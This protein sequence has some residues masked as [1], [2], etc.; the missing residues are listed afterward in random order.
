MKKQIY[1]C[2]NCGR[3]L[4]FS[5]DAEYTFYCVDCGENFHDYEVEAEEQARMEGV[6]DY[7]ELVEAYVKVKEI[8]ESAVKA[9]NKFIKVKGQ[10][11]LEQIA[12]YINE[13]LKPIFD[14]GIYEDHKFKDSAA[15]YT[16]GL[17]LTFANYLIGDKRYQA[18]FICGGNVY[19][20]FN[21]NHEYYIEG[22][23]SENLNWVVK[24]WHELK[25]S[26]NRMIPY[27]IERCNEA[28]QRALKKQKEISE[29]I[30]SFR[31]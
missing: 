27:A 10:S 20:Y 24:H 3:A 6:V 19:I 11:I 4:N 12:V 21:T 7:T 25:D 8:T 30:N 9:N 22:I 23:G 28:N 18:G 5:D 26:M 31:L 15:I 13:T 29:I 16:S 2:P 17:R 14:T 1:V